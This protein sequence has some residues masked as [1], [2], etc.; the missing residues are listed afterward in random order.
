M[1]ATP[2]SFPVVPKEV[3]QTHKKTLS[4]GCVCSF[5]QQIKKSFT[6]SILEIKYFIKEQGK[7]LERLTGSVGRVC[8]S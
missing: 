8:N 6:C 1:S 3:L 4:E 2:L 7:K 5:H